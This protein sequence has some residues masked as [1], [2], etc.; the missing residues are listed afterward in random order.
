MEWQTVLT[1]VLTCKNRNVR[2][3]LFVQ[4]QV[5]DIPWQGVVCYRRG[6]ELGDQIWPQVSD[7]PQMGH[8]RGIYLRSDSV[9]FG[10][11]SQNV[12]KL[13]LK[14][15]RFVPFG[16]NLT[17]FETN[18]NIPLSLWYPWLELPRPESELCLSLYTTLS[19][20]CYIH[21]ACGDV[22]ISIMY[23]STC[24]CLYSPYF[25]MCKLTLDVF[26]TSIVM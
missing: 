16:T 13:I 3:D 2:L 19:T 23:R 11:P 26:D 7:W 25:Y 6:R 10:S 24:G 8:I 1:F 21:E 20:H 5:V 14:S 12:L 17:P 15:P 22:H 9:H 4:V 18:P